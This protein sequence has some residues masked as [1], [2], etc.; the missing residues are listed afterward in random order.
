MSVDEILHDFEKYS[1][2]YKNGGITVSGGEALLQLPFVL[3]LFKKA[4]Q[5]NIHTCL[6]T[7][8]ACYRGSN[9]NMYKELLSYT[10]LVLLDIKHIDDEKHIKL[11]N[12]T[13]KYVLEFAELL[14]QLMIPTIVRHVLIPT[15]TD[16]ENDLK[17]LRNFIDNLNNVMHIEILPY[18]IEGVKKWNDMGI[19]Y[20]LSDIKEPTDEMIEKAEHILK[21]C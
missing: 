18:H 9:I 5:R 20:E 16:D 13:N 8:A 4:K 15:I 19:N 10:N 3:E 17:K 12:Y 2:F 21:G 7:S 6:D 1:H 11:T 14:N